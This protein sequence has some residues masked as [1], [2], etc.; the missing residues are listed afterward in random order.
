MKEILRVRTG[1]HCHGT[2]M[3]DSD[4]DIRGIIV[5][6]LDYFFGT[7]HFEQIENR[8]SDQVFYSFPKFIKLAMKGNLSALNFL[9]VN[10][11]DIRYVDEFGQRLIDF[12]QN[13]ITHNLIDCILGYCKSQLHRMERG[14]GRSGN[15]E[16]LVKLH[17]YDTKFAYHA[18]MITNIGVEVMKTGTYKALRSDGE[19]KILMKIRTGN[20]PYEETMRMIKENLTVISTLEPLSK[21]PKEPD[22]EKVDKFCE[23]F[24]LDF[25]KLKIEKIGGA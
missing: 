13:F 3:P 22:R 8:E 17:G 16:D 25:F 2:S 7:K 4:E 14:S 5:P 12:R 15:R 21:I 9:F 18:V 6:P 24:L 11:K 19:Q 1:S 23:Q 10:K 20:V